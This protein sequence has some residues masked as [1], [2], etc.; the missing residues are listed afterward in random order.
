MKGGIR[1]RREQDKTER[2]KRVTMKQM[3]REM[4]GLMVKT[5]RD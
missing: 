3:V 4:Q 5:K 1:K 2:R